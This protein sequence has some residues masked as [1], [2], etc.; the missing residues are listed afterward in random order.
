MPPALL[1]IFASQSD[2]D[3]SPMNN[4]AEATIMLPNGYWHLGA[5]YR[6]ARV[7]AIAECDEALGEALSALAHP[8]ERATLLLSRCVTRLG[9]LERMESAGVRDLSMGDREALLLH[10]RRL[11]FG[12]RMQCVLRCVACNEPM[13]L[14]LQVSDLLVPAAKIPQQR[15]Q[16]L[17]SCDDARFR[18]SFRIPTGA[19][20]EAA[21]W[22][23]NCVP[24]KA[25]PELLLRCVESV[26][27]EDSQEEYTAVSTENWPPA[28]VEKISG[29]LAE[30]DAQ[31]EIG[32]QL[33]CPVCGHE[34][35][36]FVDVTSYLVR[37]LET[38]ERQLYQE[39]HQLALA[40]HWSENE[41]L[42]MSPRK[43]NLYLDLLAGEHLA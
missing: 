24:E 1:A 4:L 36:S 29:R 34:F 6:E 31:A 9:D 40:Y 23:G 10:I 5:C 15:Y 18:V 28:L 27:R 16:E 8:I 21:I 26:E 11:T 43:R 30:A 25:V 3:L 32:L 7:R 41:I 14:E 2:G 12:E 20:V 13:D 42:K 19:D 37:E 38:R 39:V 35:P 33:T 17:F 22:A